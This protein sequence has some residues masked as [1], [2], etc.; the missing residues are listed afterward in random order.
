MRNGLDVGVVLLIQADDG[1][2]PGPS[3]HQRGES[4]VVCDDGVHDFT[5]GSRSVRNRHN[6]VDRHGFQTGKQSTPGLT[7]A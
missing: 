7:E 3:A 1:H 4:I 6:V 5:K 2:L